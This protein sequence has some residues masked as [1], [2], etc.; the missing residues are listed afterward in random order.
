LL[1]R[2]E[3]EATKAAPSSSP[4]QLHHFDATFQTMEKI[5][6]PLSQSPQQEPAISVQSP[7]FAQP[8]TQV[9]FFLNFSSLSFCFFF[10][11]EV[12]SLS[13]FRFEG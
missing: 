3:P 4:Q 10:E 1:S 11:S 2:K 6:T 8:P 13:S 12:I 7:R 5:K 9:E